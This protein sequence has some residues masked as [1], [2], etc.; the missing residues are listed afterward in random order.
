[1]KIKLAARVA[2]VALAVLAGAGDCPSTGGTAGNIL[3]AGV[4]TESHKQ[5]RISWYICVKA[6]NDP[7]DTF[8]DGHVYC[9][10]K[11]SVDRGERC[12]VGAR[13]PD[14]SAKQN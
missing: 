11:E 6:D 4:V 14:C 8:S 13:W 1:M 10:A 9:N 7:K 3:P 5:G 12:K 2:W